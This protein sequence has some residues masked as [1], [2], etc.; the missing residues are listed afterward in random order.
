MRLRRCPRRPMENVFTRATGG[1]NVVG[2]TSA[3]PP[4][5]G[6]PAPNTAGVR[7][8][9][10]GWWRRAGARHR[11]PVVGIPA[12]AL[13]VLILGASATGS[14]PSR[15][16]AAVDR[17]LT[18]RRD[19]LRAA[20]DGP[21]QRQDARADGTGV[22]VVRV[23]GAPMD[24]GASFCAK[25]S[26]SGGCSGLRRADARDRVAASTS[27]GRSGTSRTA[28]CT[29][30]S[31]ARTSSATKRLGAQA[32]RLRR[33]AVAAGLGPDRSGRGPG[34]RRSARSARR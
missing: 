30:F 33:E 32:R 28:R 12:I 23:D 18:A 22:R 14:G 1:K 31:R 10:A 19:P 29:T 17:G 4:G 15:D 9:L 2:Y 16:R 25:S 6:G 24:F 27:C 13:L 26:S 7:L 20:H 5:A 34:R 3:P 8:W 11:R 21:H